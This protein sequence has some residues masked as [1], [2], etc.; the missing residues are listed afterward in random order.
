VGVV[1]V[2]TICRSKLVYKSIYP[3]TVKQ[4]S[5]YPIQGAIEVY[6]VGEGWKRPIAKVDVPSM[7]EVR[8]KHRCAGRH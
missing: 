5:K 4:F 6:A 8:D 1:L 2:K 7:G 3:L